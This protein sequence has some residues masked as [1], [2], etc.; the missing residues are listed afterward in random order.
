MDLSDQTNSP[1]AILVNSADPFNAKTAVGVLRYG[2]APILALVDPER[3][4]KTAADVYGIRPDVPIVASVRDVPAGA[5]RLLVGIASR[6]GQLPDEMRAEIM[7]AIE[8][9]MDVYNGLHT[10]LTHDPG[11]AEAARA[12]GVRLVD[13]RDVPEDLPVGL[14]LPHRPG[15]TVVLTVGSDCNVGKMSVAL[16]LDLLARQRGLSSSFVATGQTG[17]MIA[18]SGIAVDRVISDFMAGAIEQLVVP[19]AEQHDWVWVEGQ[20]SLFHPG[21]SGVTM[22]LMHGTAPEMMILCHQPTRTCIRRYDD[23]PIPSLRTVLRAYEEAASWRAPSIVVAVALNTYDLNEAAA[24]DAIKRAEDDLGLPATDV[25]RFGA[26]KL[27]DAVV[28]QPAAAAR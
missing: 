21:Y 8:R 2:R 10:F 14:G 19:A 16:E 23:V 17:I 13:L 6:G 3:A 24:R 4:G 1:L 9:G 22:G 11:I 18:G 25:I 12:K 15:S 26:A 28:G 27:L 7:A 5:G 20:G